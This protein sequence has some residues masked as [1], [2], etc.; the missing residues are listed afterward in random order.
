MQRQESNTRI[1]G[2]TFRLNYD[3]MLGNKKTFISVGSYYNRSN[4]HV[5]V[6]A[7]FKKKP[8]GTM[9]ALALLS[10]DFWF[11]QTVGNLRGSV[12]QILGENF[13]FT[14]GT[15]AEKTNIWFEL[16]KE[17]RDVK[18]DYLTWLPFANINKT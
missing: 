4:N 5:L 9:E 15:S 2:H 6:D 10:N 13:S 18:N 8:E 17:G 12:K 16:L 14:L 1:N 7:S 11:H 3:K